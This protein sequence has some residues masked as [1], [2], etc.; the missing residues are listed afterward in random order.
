MHSISKA[1]A[2]ST[3]FVASNAV[4]TWKVAFWSGEFCA[5]QSGGIDQGPSYP[6]LSQVCNPIPNI[7][8]TQAFDFEVANGDYT[9]TLGLHKSDDCSDSGGSYQSSPLLPDHC[10]SVCP[11]WY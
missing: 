2:L 1:L 3:L 11:Q 4:K 10:L 5:S 7:G 9:Y 6:Q 8:F